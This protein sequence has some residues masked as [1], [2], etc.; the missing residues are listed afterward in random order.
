MDFLVDRDWCKCLARYL[1]L[2]T[3]LLV[4]C[5]KPKESF[6]A[7]TVYTYPEERNVLVAV[8]VNPVQ[9]EIIK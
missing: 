6:I 4:G 7:P 3:V 5:A 2:V 9:I 8:P 1:C